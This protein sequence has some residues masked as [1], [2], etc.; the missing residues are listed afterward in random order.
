MQESFELVAEVRTDKGKG[1]SRRLRRMNKVPAVLYGGR[2]DPVALT[3]P[4][5]ELVQ[6]LENEAFYSHILN[7]KVDGKSEKAVLRDVQRHPSD[8]IIMHI[9]LLRVDENASITMSVP[10]H[11]TNEEKC[12][13]VKTGGGSITHLMTQVEVSCLA[14]DLPEYIEV[15]LS[16][17]EAGASVHLSEITLPKGVE[18]VELAHGHD[19]AVVSV[20]KPRGATADEEA[21]P[22]GEAPAAGEE[23]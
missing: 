6:H 4:H 10:L 9:D 22:S 7:V 16:T 17:V 18:L 14:R 19:L 20:L 21:A 8:P 2:K 12:V 5:N 11:F 3:L 23:S 13:G 15:D 1:A